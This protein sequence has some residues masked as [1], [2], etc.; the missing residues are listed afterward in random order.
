MFIYLFK[1]LSIQTTD[2]EIYDTMSV[3]IYTVT[4]KH[5]IDKISWQ[6]LYQCYFSNKVL[7]KELSA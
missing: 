4:P 7:S 1:N 5:G 6:T 3:T 2:I